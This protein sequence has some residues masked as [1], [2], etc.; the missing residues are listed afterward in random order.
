MTLQDVM[1]ELEQLGN[2]GTKK[3]LT[4]HGAREP[5]FGVKVGDLKK[6]VKKIKV[7]HALA[8]EL[9]ATGNS[10]AMYLAALICD[11]K[12]MSVDDLDRWA[13]GAYWYMIAEYSVAWVAAESGHGFEVA[14]RWIDSG[15][16]NYASAGWATLGSLLA[17][18]PNEELDLKE[19]QSLLDRVNKTIHSELNRVRYTMNGFVIAVGSY[20]EPLHTEAIAVAEAIG[21][22]EVYTGETSCKVPLAAPYIGKATARGSLTK[23][24]KKVRC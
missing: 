23:K 18:T 10:D 24:K 9:Y 11:P 19:I 6:I 1:A 14:R 8:L 16:E 2:P 12:Q 15:Q 4:K 13:E 17:L 3:I 5:F 7:D 22:V 21:K 20:V